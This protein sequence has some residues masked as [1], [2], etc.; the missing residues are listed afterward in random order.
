M[1]F[2]ADLC[3]TTDSPTI[4]VAIIYIDVDRMIAA[5]PVKIG[6]N[7]VD[8]PVVSPA[9]VRYKIAVTI[10]LTIL[11]TYTRI[12]EMNF[13]RLVEVHT[14]SKINVPTT[15]QD[16]NTYNVFAHK[17]KSRLITNKIDIAAIKIAIPNRV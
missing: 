15:A 17:G 8:K 3:S 2:S 13:I 14:T 11:R 16:H 10:I 5:T 4:K 7:V 9:R 12:P 6:I 1:L